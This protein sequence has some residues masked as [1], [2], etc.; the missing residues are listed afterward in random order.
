MQNLEEIKNVVKEKLTEKRYNHSLGAMKA[1][2]ELAKIYSEDVKEAEF[3]RL[4]TW[5]SKRAKQ[6][7]NRSSTRKI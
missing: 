6:R 5:H 3:A 7:R 1:A 2:G 4:N